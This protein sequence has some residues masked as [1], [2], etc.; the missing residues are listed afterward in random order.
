LI[1][2]LL[3]TKVQRGLSVKGKV[4]ISQ[5]GPEEL[6]P[7]ISQKEAILDVVC[8]EERSSNAKLAVPVLSSSEGGG[9]Q[10]RSHY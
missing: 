6:D 7:T 10:W 3:E 5:E 4:G 9:C 2:H 1:I 8:L